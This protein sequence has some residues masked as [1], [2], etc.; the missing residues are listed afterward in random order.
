[1]AG[2]FDV[3]FSYSVRD[4]A[5]VEGTARALTDAGLRVFLDRWYLTPGQ[6]WP[7]ALERTLAAC[8]AVAVFIGAEGLGPWQQRERDIALD[9]QAHEPG[10]PVIPVLL[11]GGDPAL[12]FLKL[13]TWLDLSRGP[14][15][16]EALSILAAA[17]RREPPG[18]LAQQYSDAARAA[19][20][21]YRGLR[22]FREEDEPF[23]FGRNSFAETLTDA[24]LRKPFVAVV[25]ASGS[26]KSS[27]VRAGLIPR[28]RRGA[29]DRVWDAITLVPTDRPLTS[30]AAALLP[31]LEPDLSEVD[32]L[33]EVKKLAGHLANGTIGLRDVAGR[34]LAKQPGTDRLLLFVDQWEELYTQCADDAV[35][36]AFV[37]QLLESA[38]DQVFIVLTIRG[39]F[40]GRALDNRDLA[41]RLQDAVVPIGPMTR[42]ELKNSVVRPAEKTGLTW[43]PGLAEAI[44]DD[45]GDEPGGLPLLEFLL[46]GLWAERRGNLL[47][48]EAYQRLGR[49]SGAIAYRADA[50]F[51]RLNDA[52]RQAAQ[53]LLMRMV[54]PGEGVEDTRRRAVLHD[55]D[56]VADTTIQTLARERLIVTERDGGSG[57]VTVEVAHEALIR[58]W[59]RLRDWIDADREFLRTRERVAAQAL[60]WEDDK[61]NPERLL[62]PGRP[63]AEGKDLL[64]TRR[65]DLDRELIVY[66]EESTANAEAEEERARAIQ[67]RRV[68]TARLIAAAMAVLAIVAGAGGL[69]AWW[70]RSEAQRNGERAA[71]NAAEAELN[72][73]RSLATLS[74][75]ETN[76]GSPATALRVALAAVPRSISVTDQVYDRQAEKAISNAFQNLRELRRCAPNAAGLHAVAFSPDGQLLATGS[77]SYYLGIKSW[78]NTVRL[79][80]V[81]TCRLILAFR[82][83]QFSVLSVSFSPDGKLLATG[84]EDK[85]VQLW[86]VATG[87]EIST[88]RGHGEWV[89]S[90][91][92]S[93]DGRTLATASDDKTARLWDVATSSEI[94]VLRGHEDRVKSVAFSPDGRTLAT[95]S[96]DKT[97]RLWD[98]ASRKEV[99]TLLGHDSFIGSVTFSPDSKLLATGS[100]DKT[101]RL[102]DV[103]TGREITVFR[104]SETAVSSV[105]FSPDGQILATNSWKS[106]RG[107]ARLWKVATGK[108]ITILRGHNGF[109]TSVVF[110]P[111]GSLLATGSTDGS[112][113][114]W[115]V[116]GQEEAK[117]FRGHNSFVYT[118]AFSPDGKLLATGSYDKTARVW[119]VSTGKEITALRGHEAIVHSVAFSPNCKL[120]AT[121]SNEPTARLWEV[122]TGKNASILRG[123]D[124]WVTSVTFSPDGRTMA[125]GSLDGTARLWAVATGQ[126]IAVLPVNE[127]GTVNS[128]D[129][130]PD[131]SLLATG[132]WDNTKLWAVASGSE[133]RSFL[134]N[135]RMIATF[136]PDGK[137][138]ASAFEDLNNPAVRLRQV[139]SGKEVATFLGDGRGVNSLTYSPDGKLLAI[140]SGG[141]AYIWEVSTGKEITVFRSPEGGVSSV[142]FSPDGGTLAISA[143][144]IAQLWPVGQNLIDLACARVHE[145]PLDERDKERFGITDEWCTP[146]VS[147]VLRAKLGLEK[148]DSEVAPVAV[149]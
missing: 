32:R 36:Q 130:N 56:E 76:Y 41:D 26:G 86:E 29:G 52:E 116:T 14:T 128:V 90:V 50:V 102:W 49:V 42:H 129:F 125:T 16:A 109:V 12:G 105:A 99:R 148:P 66:I 62:P 96:W 101:A 82:A 7:Q 43:E 92:F 6:P 17:I 124:N 27:V 141:I 106:W 22:P 80:D 83:K 4:H 107:M 35:R 18:P 67:R 146:Q 15:D 46:E 59:Q 2:A 139:I 25:G 77:L 136:S 57:A 127:R 69:L 37:G 113:R 120:L 78:D 51:E 65:A 47:T 138:I 108:E 97:A 94:G 70:Q 45:V 114:L 81:K 53:R 75:L 30:L 149:Q 54:R 91:A 55:A 87:K 93:P 126:A 8:S 89:N 140:A 39:D 72:L 121:S 33:A 123:H 104:G 132:S 118:V 21:P 23:F 122:T 142:D 58:R 63:L 28:L 79:W 68:R 10:F 11:G 112:A 3:F 64:M 119:D 24:V 84:S 19:V 103:A 13:N 40:M 115:K 143:G 135:Q 74:E 95:G 147:G 1:M 60:L 61:R 117:T 20:C 134:D 111:D 110:S 34:V 71:R 100:D 44:L 38:S 85:T 48:H 137:L 5:A 88:F 98:L 73:S 31:A 131:G 133:V 144:F 9:R 145:L